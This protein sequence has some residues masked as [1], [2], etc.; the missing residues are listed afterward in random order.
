MGQ[1]DKSV[2]K[3]DLFWVR[4]QNQLTISPKWLLQSEVDTRM[5]Y[6]PLKEHHLVIRSQARYTLHEQVQAGVGFTYA[7]QYPQDPRS[8]SDLVIR[9]LRAQHD[10]TLKQKVAEATINHRYMLEERFIRKVQENELL[11][12][13]NFNFRFRY[14]L[15]AEIPLIHRGN[16]NL[17]LV[18]YDEVMLNFGKTIVRNVFDQNRIYGGVKCGLS[19]AFAMEIGYLFWYQQRSSG[20]DFY[21]R[22][23][24]RLSIYHKVNLKRNDK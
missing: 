4:Y 17:G 7:L 11:P 23:I 19:P 3:Q 22:D 20:K 1:A 10:I 21:S 18:L 8:K 6:R 14:R 12:G 13:Y 15:Q 24:A 2:L 9:E 5:Y 16:Q